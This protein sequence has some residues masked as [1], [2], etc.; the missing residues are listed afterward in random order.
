M[1]DD[2]FK[3]KVERLNK[4]VYI[5]I[6]VIATLLILSLLGLLWAVQLWCKG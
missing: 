4:Q 6:L 3:A 5:A 1:K 2:D